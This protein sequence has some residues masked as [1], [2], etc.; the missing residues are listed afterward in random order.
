MAV[1]I[2]PGTAYGFFTDT[3]ICIG[4]KACEVACK[5]WNQLP[6]NA[7]KFLGDSLDNTGQLDAMN[8]RHVQFIEQFTPR[9]PTGPGVA[10]DVRRLQAL[11]PGEL[12]GRVPDRRDH[13]HRVRHR[14]HPAGRLQ[15]LPQ[16]HQRL[17]LRGHRLQRRLR[18]RPQVHALLRPPPGGDAAGLRPGVPDPVD[19][20]RPARPAPHSGRRPSRH[21]ARRAN[22]DARLYGAT[23][24]AS[25]GGWRLLPAH[26][27]ARDVRSAGDGERGPAG[28]NNGPGYLGAPAR[29]GPR[30]DRRADRLPPPQRARR[31]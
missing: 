21:A 30:R 29:L 9:A 28:R 16:L 10:D 20:L 24:R 8:W 18:H 27:Q 17:P 13:P 5:E 1:R 31:G 15:R 23:I 11:Q 4:C 3:S 19:P 2:S 6:G 14:L 7:P 25:T 26:G 22:G 12:H